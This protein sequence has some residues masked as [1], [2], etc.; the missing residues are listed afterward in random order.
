MRRGRC[1]ER[2]VVTPG[3][4]RAAA[5]RGAWKLFVP[6]SALSGALRQEAVKGVP[7]RGGR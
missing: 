7:A 6:G 2:F 1:G 5:L 4:V 3:A